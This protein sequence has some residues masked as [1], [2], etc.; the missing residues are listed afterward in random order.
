M[1][2]ES[3][4]IFTSGLEENKF[5]IPVVIS[6]LNKYDIPFNNINKINTLHINNSKNTTYLFELL[7]SVIPFSPKDA[8]I[9]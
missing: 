7:S 2:S 6:T 8:N 4:L 1:L 9:T 3:T 5:F